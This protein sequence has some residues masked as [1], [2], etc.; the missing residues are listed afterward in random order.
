MATEPAVP[1]LPVRP[2]TPTERGDAD[3]SGEG[4]A[5][6]HQQH[7]RESNRGQRRD[8]QDTHEEAGSN[9]DGPGLRG[10]DDGS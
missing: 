8:G 1:A 10:V 4:S 9:S 7:P 2:T 6:S 5:Y 3:Y